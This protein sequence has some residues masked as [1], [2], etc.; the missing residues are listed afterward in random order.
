MLLWQIF[1]LFTRVALFS[2][3]GGPASLAL[4]QRECTAAGWVTPDQFADAVALGNAPADAAVVAA[5]E[6][7][8]DDESALLR[9]H[10]GWALAA[11]RARRDASAP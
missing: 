8:R 5:L 2:W 9:E 3:G 10:V 7:R 11:Q 6:A 4:M 1:W